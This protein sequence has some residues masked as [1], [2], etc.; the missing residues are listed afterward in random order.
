MENKKNDQFASQFHFNP[1]KE[2]LIGIEREAF[3]FSEGGIKPISKKI[4]TE[5]ASHNPRHQIFA[6]ELSACQIEM[7]YGPFQEQDLDIGIDKAEDERRQI[8][9]NLGIQLVFDDVAYGISL[10]VYPD[11]AGR[12]QSIADNMP[13]KKLEA[14]CSV[15]GTHIHIGLPSI[16]CALSVYGK[17]IKHTDE[18]KRMGDKSN[19]KRL[20]IY[21]KAAGNSDPK[22]LDNMTE[23][24]DDAKQK[25]YYDDPRKCWYFIRI[26]VHG[27]IEFRMFSST[28]DTEEIKRWAR[29]CRDLVLE[30]RNEYFNPKDGHFS[31]WV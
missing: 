30:Y 21:S 13:I 3:I 31:V 28:P 26:S 2:L 23:W 22:P 27:T 24:V 15:A 4:L 20:D 18:L 11:E 7:K 25:G 16:E 19:G 5:I 14:A 9:K 29:Y 6:P 8:E 17:L 10:D 1:E 12:Y